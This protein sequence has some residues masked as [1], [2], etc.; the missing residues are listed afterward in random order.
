MSVIDLSIG[1]VVGLV[2]S[3]AILTET[4]VAIGFFE[5]FLW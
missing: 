2:I 1:G 3:K 5:L 4:D